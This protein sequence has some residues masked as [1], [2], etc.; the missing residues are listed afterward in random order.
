MELTQFVSGS[1]KG[2]GVRES[3]DMKM[4]SRFLG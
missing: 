3:E 4:T 2:T 1:N